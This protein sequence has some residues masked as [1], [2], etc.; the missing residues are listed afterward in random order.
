MNLIKTAQSHLFQTPI[1][2]GLLNNYQ[3]DHKVVVV[4]QKEIKKQ[5]TKM[6]KI[7]Q[8]KEKQLAKMSQE[9]VKLEENLP[10]LVKSAV[11]E[12][13]QKIE[14]MQKNEAMRFRNIK[15]IN[16][17][18]NPD[19]KPYADIPFSYMRRMAQVYPVARACINRR[20][21][22]ITQLE[23]DITTIDEEKEETGYKEQIKVIKD[24]FKRPMGHKTRMREM[25]TTMVDDVLTV[26][27]ISFEYQRMRSGQFMYLIP[28]DPT[29][30]ALKV[31]DQ[32]ATPEP[33]D[34]AYVQIIQ[35]QKIAEFTTDEMLYEFMGNRSSSPYGLAPLE[36]LILQAEAAIRGTLYNLN[37]FKE[38]NVPEGFITL[39][40]DVASNKERVEEWQMWFDAI[41]AGDDRMT[42]RLKILPGGAEYTAAKKP[43]DM[44]FERFELWLLQLTCAI[45]DVQPQDIGITININKASGET[46]NDIG[47]ERGLFPLANFLK[48]IFDDIIQIE[49]QQP[50]LQW[51][52]S[53]INPVDRKEEVEIAEKEIKM[54]ALGV[55][56]YRAEQGR[57]P[58]GLKPYIVS[59]NTVMLVDDFVT[60]KVGPIADG[61]RADEAAKQPKVVVGGNGPGV[62]QNNTAKKIEGE[63]D[64][65]QELLELEDIRKWRKCIYADLDHG[66]SL[67]LKFQSENIRPEVHEEI[68]TLLQK[69]NSKAAAKLVFDQFIDPELK[70]SM[71]L[72]KFAKQLRDLEHD[73]SA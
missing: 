3:K 48:E 61:K 18:T 55:D 1:F 32:G 40:E 23:W 17:Q 45:F 14:T 73:L 26:D 68:A 29:T 35:G 16:T 60:G 39:P 34:T 51:V 47:K 12:E 49:F 57:E 21:R 20:I 44:A 41:V 36:S 38:N 24:F 31:T 28:V 30:I 72:V 69:V 67:R 53:N 46:Q 6:S 19:R 5:K 8:E 2:K 10:H 50:D 54:G 71:T 25:L 13:V 33:P 64:L 27:A 42:H 9:K 15:K 63:E 11:Q 58:L 66:R 70:A 43:E 37:Y 62:K 52:W 4:P 56:E 65:D 7:L 22:Q 59:G